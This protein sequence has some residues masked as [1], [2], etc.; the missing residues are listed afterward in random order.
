MKK[1]ISQVFHALECFKWGFVKDHFCVTI[2]LQ[3]GIISE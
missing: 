2:I 1:Q 3:N